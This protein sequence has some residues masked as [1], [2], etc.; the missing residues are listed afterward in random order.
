MRNELSKPSSSPDWEER[1]EVPSLQDLTDADNFKKPKKV[2]L[3]PSF[4]REA[5]DTF[6]DYPKIGEV[7]WFYV[8]VGGLPPLE[9]PERTLA[10]HAFRQIMF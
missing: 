5:D 10:D 1:V 3:I 6:V 4:K 2:Q 9:G 7:P 8:N